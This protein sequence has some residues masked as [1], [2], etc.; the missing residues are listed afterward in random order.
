M[1]VESELKGIKRQANTSEGEKIKLINDYEVLIA[2]LQD[3]IAALLV[4]SQKRE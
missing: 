3:K 1:N 4:E 2:S